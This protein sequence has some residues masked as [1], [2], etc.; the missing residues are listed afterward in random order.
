MSG[1]NSNSKNVERYSRALTPLWSLEEEMDKREKHFGRTELYST[2]DKVM[3]EYLGG[4]YPGGYGCEE[5]YELVLIFGDTGMNK[6][7]LAS[8]LI[9]EPA[10]QGKKI[11]YFSL[12]DHKADVGVRIR[13]QAGNFYEQVRKNI[14]F[15]ADCS[16]YVLSDLIEFIDQ[17][18]DKYDIV[19]LDPIQFAF[20]ASV[21]ESGEA[22]YNRQRLFMR[23]LELITE[24][25]SKTIILVSHTRK[26]SGN[27]KGQEEGLDRIIGSSGLAQGTT[28][29]IEIN[30]KDGVPGIRIWK[31]RFG[32]GVRPVGLPIKIWDNMRI[33]AQYDYYDKDIITFREAWGE[34]Q[35]FGAYHKQGK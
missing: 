10:K 7:T 34:P 19:V 9:I 1:N 11:A 26:R 35:G 16:G 2:G 5:G 32:K 33:T 28:K 31:N 13:H 23:K 6:S 4:S 12:E 24:K 22:E 15:T 29:V 20:E 30:R 3:D 18:Y 21:V 14:D 27:S 17:L 25:K 8:S